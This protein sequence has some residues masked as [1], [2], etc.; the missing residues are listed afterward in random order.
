MFC[1]ALYAH[2]GLSAAWGLLLALQR[3][4]PGGNRRISLHSVITRQENYWS[5]LVTTDLEDN[6][7]M[8]AFAWRGY[9]AQQALAVQK[10]FSLTLHRLCRLVMFWRPIYLVLV[11]FTD[12]SCHKTGTS[13]VPWAF[14]FPLFLTS[15]PCQFQDMGTG[16]PY[17]RR[18]A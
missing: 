18:S 14:L 6:S 11:F 2:W 1:I 12:I 9:R 16:L 15:S 3:H 4:S 17:S 10:Y 8:R 7:G 13:F 5:V